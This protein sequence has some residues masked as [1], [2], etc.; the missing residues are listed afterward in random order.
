MLAPFRRSVSDLVGMGLRLP[1]DQ[2]T[3]LSQPSGLAMC[4]WGVPDPYIWQEAGTQCLW[5]EDQ[6]GKRYPVTLPV[7]L[8]YNNANPVIDGSGYYDSEEWRGQ[9]RLRDVWEDEQDGVWDSYP[10]LIG[11]ADAPDPYNWPETKLFRIW[12]CWPITQAQAT[13][14]TT[15]TALAW[16]G[17]KNDDLHQ[18]MDF[19]SHNWDLDEAL[20]DEDSAPVLASL[21]E[22]C[23]DS[24]GAIKITVDDLTPQLDWGEH[25]ELRDLWL[26]LADHSYECWQ[27]V[28]LATPKSVRNDLKIEEGV[29]SPWF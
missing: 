19:A 6:W 13:V 28:E 26:N 20:E 9:S 3:M 11:L 5:N 10:S 7:V 18:L 23:L 16:E 4:V 1:A 25:H 29:F 8:E 27:M 22:S 17:T 12:D 2:V 15:V 24:E 21:K 14:I